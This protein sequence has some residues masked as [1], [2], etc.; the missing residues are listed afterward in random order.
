MEEQ[1]KTGRIIRRLRCH[2]QHEGR[3]NKQLVLLEIGKGGIH[4]SCWQADCCLWQ[5]E[6]LLESAWLDGG[7]DWWQ[8]LREVLQDIFIWARVPE[9]VD[10]I[11]ILE[12]ELV[13]SEQLEFPPL[14]E[15]EL[16]QAVAWETEQLLP[17]NSAEY[18]TAYAISDT[19]SAQVLVHLW[20]W[21]KEQVQLA[22]SL[23]LALHFRLRAILVGMSTEKV[24]RAWYK[25]YSFNNWSLQEE[26]PWSLVQAKQLLNS[27]YPRRFLLCCLALSMGLYGVTQ[28]ALFVAGKGL[29]RGEQELAQYIVWQER[30]AQSQRLEQTL[31]RYRQLDKRVREQT[32]QVSGSV[33]RLGKSISAGCW[34]ELLKG[35]AKSKEWLLEGACHQPELLSRLVDDLQQDPKL[36]QVR[37]QGSQQQ[38]ESFT[39]SLLVKEK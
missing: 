2:W 26:H 5:K 32:T 33:Q 35:D 23:S 39:F 30:M 27:S 34:L 11:W 6:K 22:A 36:V 13:M 20:A 14:K 29:E 10:A 3:K 15:T 19:D 4:C 17:G 7:A 24:Q 38:G 12:E 16:A 8:E 21:P 37:L 25:G 9:M 31:A 18:N 28:G 1:E